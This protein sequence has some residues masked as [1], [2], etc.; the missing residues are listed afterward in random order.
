M[1]DISGQKT[2]IDAY[3][4]L[5]DALAVANPTRLFWATDLASK[6]RLSSA[7]PD[8]L[9]SLALGRGA[10]ARGIKDVRFKRM[11][12]V[13]YHALR[14][15][16]RM[17]RSRGLVKRLDPSRPYTVIKTFAYDHSFGKDGKYKD[18]F[19]GRL[20]A[21]LQQKGDIIVLAQVLGNY[22]LFLRRARACDALVLPVE[23][24]LTWADL[25]QAVTEILFIPVKVPRPLPFLGH[26]IHAVV[27]GCF[28][29][30]FKGV[31]LSQFL[32]FWAV[33][34][35]ARR[36]RVR[37]FYMTYENYPW[38]RMAL[39]ALRQNSPS[40]RT[41]GIQ[42]TVVPQSFLNY[43]VSASET[44]ARL[45]PDVIYTTGARTAEI[46]RRYSSA[47]NLPVKA[48]CALRFGSLHG[49]APA[50]RRLV[51]NILLPL[52]ASLR[53]EPMV[54]WVFGQVLG[55]SRYQVR[56]RTH[57]LLPWSVCER[58]MGLKARGN[59][60]A[61]G[62]TLAED[63]A[64]ADVVVYWSTT[65]ALEALM[66]GK[67]LVHF[68]NGDLLSFDPLFECPHLK[69]TADA[70]GIL[71]AILNDIDAVPD[72]DFIRSRREAREY[73]NNYFCPVTTERLEALC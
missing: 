31:Q 33:G 9:G 25:R 15:G 2:F 58:K 54:R 65:V 11:A 45:L 38:E 3:N 48:G 59:I 39:M 21:H 60:T 26:D 68:S 23:A 42:H 71:P 63:L 8:L 73:L 19:L 41:I 56:V 30:T 53:A 52:E 46:M 34:R 67:P 57:P 61:S 16:I 44:Q 17:V 10:D 69:W 28:D 32:H 12:G 35:L 27:R 6:N 14:V 64:W 36:F 13:F 18:V 47:E 43:F 1:S 37:A 51:K 70:R 50:Q 22:D 29:R 62:A 4:A 55:N 7:L 5:L 49:I 24:F 20:P 66:M 72:A 40:T